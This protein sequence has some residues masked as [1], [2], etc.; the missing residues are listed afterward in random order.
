MKFR[1]VEK[2]AVGLSRRR[3]N[4]TLLILPHPTL[5]HNVRQPLCWKVGRHQGKLE[6]KL[7]SEAAPNL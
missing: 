3:I 6:L 4:K 2:K 1:E 5:M 7:A